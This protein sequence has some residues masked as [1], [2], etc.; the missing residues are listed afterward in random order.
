MYEI[1]QTGGK[2][3][4]LRVFQFRKAYIRHFSVYAFIKDVNDFA[5][6]MRPGSEA[7]YSQ[8]WG[9][10]FE[11]KTKRKDILKCLELDERKILKLMLEK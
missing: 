11:R 7:L 10:N 8:G 9:L 5:I 1:A 6:F 3:E 4:G 2:E